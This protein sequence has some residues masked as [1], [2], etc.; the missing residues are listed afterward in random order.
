MPVKDNNDEVLDV[1]AVV[2]SLARSATQVEEPIRLEDTDDDN[3]TELRESAEA[4]GSHERS[5]PGLQEDV[6]EQE[7]REM[8]EPP[9]VA[10]AGEVDVESDD[11][12]EPGTCPEIPQP[13]GVRADT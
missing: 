7:D 3:M 11:D 13:R 5:Q 10:V 9:V 12:W 6:V 1:D 8:R 4:S 2:T